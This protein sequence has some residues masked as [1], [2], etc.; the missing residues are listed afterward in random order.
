MADLTTARLPLPSG[1]TLNV[2]TGG[3]R[4]GEAIVFLHGFP[5]SHRT[6]REVMPALTKDYFV[7]APDQ[8]G[9]GGSDKPNGVENYR[10]EPAVGD[11][12][13]LA[14]VL[15]LERFTLVGHDWGGVVAWL[16]AAGHPDR[17]DRLV[18]VNAPHPLLFQKRLID[19]PA[20]RAASQ[21]ITAFRGGMEAA[22]VAMGM[23]AFFDLMFGNHV[24]I[25]AIPD[26]ERAAYISDWAAP[27]AL[28]AMLD[29]YRAIDIVVP[30][31]G[32]AAALPG[33]TQLPFPPIIRPTLVVWGMRDS[34]LLPVQLDGLD[35]LVEDLTV[36]RVPDAGHFIPWE[37]PAPVIAAI[38]EFLRR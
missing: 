27:G 32:E 34:A 33:W 2:A 15:G 25:A 31:V 5:E 30:A 19:D 4:G 22:A 6:W 29:W 20:Q 23:E 36:V 12:M 37:R 21:Y 16:A 35:D 18:I 28:T 9:F 26:G 17:I 13:A 8:R 24:D 11:L 38:E 7:V 1:I 14:D 3:A 10:T